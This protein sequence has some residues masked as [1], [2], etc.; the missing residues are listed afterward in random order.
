MNPIRSAIDSF[1]KEVPTTA[2]RAPFIRDAVD[3]KRVMTL[4]VVALFPCILM[5]IW[6]AGIQSIVHENLPLL[7]EFQSASSSFSGYLQFVKEKELIAR[8]LWRGGTIFLPYIAISYAVGG[9][10]EAL[11]AWIRKTEIAEGFLVSGILY[12]LILPPT[13]PYWMA[14]V[15]ISVGIVIGKELFG[16]TGMNIFNPALLCRCFLYFAFPAAMTGQIWVHADGITSPS[17]LAVYNLPEGIVKQHVDAIAYHDYGI[18]SSLIEEK[19]EKWP[20]TF[21]TFLTDELSLPADQ[22]QQVKQ[23]VELKLGQGIFADWNLFF[24]NKV[25][26]FG[27]VSIFAVLLG[28]LLLLLTRIAS[29]RIMLACLAGA[30]FT[31]WL[32]SQNTSPLSPAKFDLPIYKHLLIGGLFFGLVFMAT[33]PVSGPVMNSAKWAYGF[34]IGALTIVIRSINPAYPEGVM[35]AI[36]MANAFAPLFDRIALRIYRRPRV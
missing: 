22:I 23:F 28:A 5:A 35:L 8:S 31:A 19:W 26:S 14:A 21:H 12:P 20:G 27:E 36:L 9:F 25:G 33:D 15:G 3:L 17:A 16:G 11:F 24:G 2:K 1:L 32:F 34:F 29:W 30:L 10:W 18:Q 7:T 4:V 13:L 6:N